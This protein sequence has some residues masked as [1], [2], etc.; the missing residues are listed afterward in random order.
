MVKVQPLPRLGKTVVGQPPDPHGPVAD[1][2]RASGL[3]QASPQ[4]FGVQLL[5]Q[6]VHARARGHEAALADDGPP[7]GALATVIQTKAGADVNPVPAGRFLAP[8]A[9]DGALAPI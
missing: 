5:A 4:G 8:A 9:Q 3:A 7:A 1:D 2:Q 6:A